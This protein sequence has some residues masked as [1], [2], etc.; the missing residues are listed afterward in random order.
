MPQ[1]PARKM[2]GLL[3]E[4][5]VLF[6]PVYLGP[7]VPVDD[8]ALLILETPGDDNQEVA[9]AYPEPLLDLALYS[10][11]ARDAVLAADADVVCSEHQVGSAEDLAIPFLRQPY[12]NDLVAFVILCPSCICQLINS[13]TGGGAARPIFSWE[14]I[15]MTRA[16]I[17]VSVPGKIRTTATTEWTAFRFR[18]MMPAASAATCRES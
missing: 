11:R 17:K 5:V 3:T 16:T 8:I 12:A 9:F 10:S 13:L 2:R 1:A 15:S 6:E 14:C 7:D 18:G 4:I